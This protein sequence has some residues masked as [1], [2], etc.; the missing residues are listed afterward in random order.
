MNKLQAIELLVSEKWTKEDAKRA[1]V[2]VDFS[3]NPDELTIRKA[4]SL[5]SG[6]E[7]IHRQRLQA[8]QKTQV[9]KKTNE[10]ER[11]EKAHELEIE[12]LKAKIQNPSSKDEFLEAKVKALASQNDEL[13]RVNDGLK[14]DNKALKNLVD[15]IRL[16]TAID[17]KNLLKYEDS[18]IR[19]A[20]A[21][22]FKGIEG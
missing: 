22:W 15:R 6:T 2:G 10:I 21:K 13:I 8:A 14:K 4:T 20:L 18:E 7:L 9:T 5:F 12:K 1:L 19:R 11:L 17:V 3:A 16:K